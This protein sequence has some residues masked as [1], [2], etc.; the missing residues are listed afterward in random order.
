[1][2]LTKL[3]KEKMATK[4]MKDCKLDL[5]DKFDK[6]KEKLAT[7]KRFKEIRNREMT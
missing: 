6:A 4:A 7:K 5:V 1:M 3:K 2:A